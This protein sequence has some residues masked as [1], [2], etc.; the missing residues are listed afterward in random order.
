MRVLVAAPRARL[1]DF[2]RTTA[3]ALADAVPTCLGFAHDSSR[4]PTIEL[5]QRVFAERIDL[6]VLIQ[7]RRE[8][9]ATLDALRAFGARCV[10]WYE[11]DSPT[12]DDRPARARRRWL[13]HA[14][15]AV[16]AVDAN[17]AAGAVDR[18]GNAARI[19]GTAG[20]ATAV[21]AVVASMSIP[22]PPTA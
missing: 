19:V 11:V 5:P 20:F 22:R 15:D 1:D 6:V 13:S 14:A 2:V 3:A 8:D 21:A 9:P 4:D 17:A 7:P 10:L 16:V 12:A 18:N